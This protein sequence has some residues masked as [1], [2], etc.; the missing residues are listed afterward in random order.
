MKKKVRLE[1]PIKDLLMKVVKHCDGTYG[2]IL[3][4]KVHWDC[5]NGKLAIVSMMDGEEMRIKT[6]IYDQDKD[7]TVFISDCSRQVFNTENPDFDSIEAYECFDKMVE[8][9]KYSEL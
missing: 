1:K 3:A 9:V 8:K 4:L 2:E 7:G 6:K 5:V